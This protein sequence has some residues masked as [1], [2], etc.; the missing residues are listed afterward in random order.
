MGEQLNVT[1][2]ILTEQNDL[3]LGK[4]VDFGAQIKNQE[5]L[6]ELERTVDE[7]SRLRDLLKIPKA[8]PTF[9][10]GFIK[11]DQVPQRGAPVTEIVEPV[12]NGEV[13]LRISVLNTAQ[14]T[15]RTVVVI[16]AACVGCQYAAQDLAMSADAL[17]PLTRSKAFRRLPP[18]TRL[19]LPEIKIVPPPLPSLGSWLAWV[20]RATSVRACQSTT[21]ESPRSDELEDVTGKAHRRTNR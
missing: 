9:E 16:F 2:E 8:T 5:L 6:E 20:F 17:K 4:L 18:T 3:L 21:S 7:T 19:D 11:D 1:R 15:A 10:V 13:T 14:V 12:V